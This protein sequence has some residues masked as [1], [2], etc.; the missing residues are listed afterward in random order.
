MCSVV[1]NT[2]LRFNNAVELCVYRNNYIKK[3][4]YKEYFHILQN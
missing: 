3:Q 1:G 2:L 4:R